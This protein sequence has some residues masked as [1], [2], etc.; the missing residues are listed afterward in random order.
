MALSLNGS[1]N[2]STRMMQDFQSMTGRQFGADRQISAG[3]QFSTSNAGAQLQGTLSKVNAGLSQNLQARQSSRDAA[4]AIAQNLRQNVTGAQ[5]TTTAGSQSTQTTL[6]LSAATTRS[7]NTAG[8]GNTAST[9]STSQAIQSYSQMGN[10]TQA[11]NTVL[12]AENQS[13]QRVLS[14][15]G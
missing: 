8:L 14:L 10:L 3:R 1:T 13:P 12:T 11:R 2:L 5:D 15:L 7:T 4:N 9:L 6:D